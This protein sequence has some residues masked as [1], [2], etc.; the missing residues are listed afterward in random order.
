MAAQAAAQMAAAEMVAAAAT[1]VRRGGRRGRYG[2]R[3]CED[4]GH[5]RI[6]GR[7]VGGMGAVRRPWR[8][9]LSRGGVRRGREERLSRLRTRRCG[10][11]MVALPFYD[12][13]S[14]GRAR[15]AAPRVAASCVGCAWVDR[16]SVSC[17]ARPR[18]ASGLPGE[19]EAEGALA[20]YN[21]CVEGVSKEWR[22]R[23]CSFSS[24]SLGESWCV[25][26]GGRHRSSSSMR[27]PT[28]TCPACCEKIRGR[29][30]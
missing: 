29:G 13:R 12:A 26:R 15:A 17:G 25:D 7:G 30:R 28:P 4:D 11:H 23:L 5:G 19:S 2:R 6:G 16:V 22:E 8:S 3:G 10:G 1:A 20:A 24:S 14:S 21:R 9:G 27:S 18:A